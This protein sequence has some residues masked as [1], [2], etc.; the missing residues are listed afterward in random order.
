MEKTLLTWIPAKDFSFDTLSVEQWQRSLSAKVAGT[1][2]LHDA[3]AALS[4]DFFVMATSLV[5]KIPF[6]TQS[7]YTAANNFQEAFARYRRKM[8]LPASAVSFGLVRGVGFL[9]TNATTL[10]TMMRNKVLTLSEHQFLDCLESGF[11]DETHGGSGMADGRGDLDYDPLSRA[12]IHTCLD[13]A[14]LAAQKREEETA[15]T[16]PGPTPRWYRDGR[17]SMIVRAFDDAYRHLKDEDAAAGPQKNE[18]SR[19]GSSAVAQLREEFDKAIK[20][21]GPED[22]LSTQALVTSAIVT[23]VA[24]MLAMDAAGVSEMKSVADYGVDSLIAAELR[25]WFNVA[26]KTN[27]SRLDLLDPQTTI[28]SLAGIVVDKALESKLDSKASG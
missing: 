26:F 7:A 25:N 2:N 15:G 16:A 8:G 20:N 10:G 27:I 1:R 24:E 22:R 14:L 3:T 19:G 28:K 11:L 4:L 12:E 17:L 18:A 23:T 6:A 21:G 9:G 13:P 5:T